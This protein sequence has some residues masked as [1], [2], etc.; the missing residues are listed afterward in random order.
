MS[1]R[2]LIGSEIGILGTGVAVMATPS[3]VVFD[4]GDP[5]DLHLPSQ[6][7]FTPGCR[8]VIVLGGTVDTNP[9]TEDDGL[10]F[11]V[12]DAED[13]AGRIAVDTL[14]LAVTDDGE[15]VGPI[16]HRS[17][18]IGLLMRANRPWLRVEAAKA[19]S[20]KVTGR[21]VVLAFP[22]GC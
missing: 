10:V 6:P 18:T 22:A 13:D 5:G 19:N 17:I 1:A 4:F 11:A 20:T 21:A 2:A 8:V 12:K 14:A 16:G 15:R 9:G 7:G 3:T